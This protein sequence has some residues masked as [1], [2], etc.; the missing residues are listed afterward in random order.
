MGRQYVGFLMAFRTLTRVNI[1]IAQF[2]RAVLDDEVTPC[3]KARK[4]GLSALLFPKAKISSYASTQWRKQVGEGYS[5][6]EAAM[7]LGVTRDVVYFLI[8]KGILTS[9]S[10]IGERCTNLLIGK[11]DLAEFNLSYISP[12]GIAKQLG[13]TSGHLTRLLS[14]QGIYPVSGPQVDGGRQ[15]VI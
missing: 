7:L 14:T 12:A 4:P 8:R 5:V 15:Y 1:G 6:V 10:S 9:R 2:L 13:T 3:G 11:D